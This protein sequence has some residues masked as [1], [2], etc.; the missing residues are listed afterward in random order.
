M[1]LS[2]A[3]LYLLIAYQIKHWVADYPLQTEYMLGKFSP[4][5]TIWLP[6]LSLHALVHSLGT[7]LIVS[8][9]LFFSQR[10]HTNLWC[11]SVIVGAALFD[12]VIHFTMDR[13]KASASMLGRFK[14]LDGSTFMNMKNI[15]KNANEDSNT[16]NAAKKRLWDNKFFWW[17]LGFDQAIHHLTHYAIIFFLITQ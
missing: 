3:F 4:T 8:W 5:P 9:A 10:I 6:A 1:A 13:V 14:Q 7:A 12:F 11:W 15:L 16:L 2:I 17:A